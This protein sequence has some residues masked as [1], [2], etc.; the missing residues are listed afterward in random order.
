VAVPG[1]PSC[2]HGLL[3]LSAAEAEGQE[4]LRFPGPAIIER[5]EWHLDALTHDAEGE[6]ILIPI[7]TNYE[8]IR[9]HNNNGR[10]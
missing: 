10:N 9:Q 6:I 1:S 7:D 2:A 5:H 8:I 4:A 3:G